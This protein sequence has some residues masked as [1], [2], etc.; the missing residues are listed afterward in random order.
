[1]EI[2]SLIN[3]YDTD[4]MFESIKNFSNQFSLLNKIDKD[5]ALKHKYKDINRVL[6]LG[7][8]G[9]AIGADIFQ[10]MF[11]DDLN[12]SIDV[13]RGYSLPKWL[14]KNTLV[15]AYSYSG[16]TEE[17]IN[18]FNSCSDD[19]SKI[20]VSSGGKLLKIANSQNLD[21]VK[22]PGGEQP[23]AALGYSIS[24]YIGLFSKLGFLDN[25]ICC[26]IVEVA[27]NIKSFTKDI[28]DDNSYVLSIA[29][30]LFNKLP[31][32]YSENEST[33]SIGIRF[34]NQ[35]QENGKILA[36]S[37]VLPELNHNEIEG[38]QSDKLVLDNIV[39]LWLIGYNE[40]L[41]N[42]NR[43]DIT[44]EIISSFNINQN[45]IRIDALDRF[46]YFLKLI[47][48]IDWIS[49]YCGILNKVNPSPVPQIS[50]LKNK[51]A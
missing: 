3:K 2:L 30:K 19:I 25:N 42:S 45:T 39:I 49:F 40:N 35:L 33:K 18:A 17:T 13:N 37:S 11:K 20:I 48:L 12:I 50:I 21:Y 15:I 16:N 51:L 23:R 10:D 36:Y 32:I 43:R 28:I 46:D 34:A 47:H 6:V 31:I 4:N 1:M 14:N 22:I 7:M 5:L 8:G 26:K 41:Q 27:K 9:S 44:S 29:K 24:S 38:Y